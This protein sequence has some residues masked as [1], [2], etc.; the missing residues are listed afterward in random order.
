MATNMT[1]AM[2]RADK[3]EPQET[4]KES[5]QLRSKVARLEAQLAESQKTELHLR[6]KVLDLEV[7]RDDARECHEEQLIK[8]LEHL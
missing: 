4:T 8:E 3:T 1:H 2:H 6:R 5:S 7:M